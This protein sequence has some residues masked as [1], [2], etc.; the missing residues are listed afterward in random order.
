[1]RPPRLQ[2]VKLE[3]GVFLN[4]DADPTP[5]AFDSPPL[6]LIFGSGGGGGGCL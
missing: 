2:E 3:S 1:M 4:D 6:D 5:F